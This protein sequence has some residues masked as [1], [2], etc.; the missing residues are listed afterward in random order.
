MPLEQIGQPVIFYAFYTDSGEGAVGLTV[1]ASVIEVLADGTA[2]EI[3]TDAAATEIGR[4]LYRYRLV[5]ASVDAQAEYIAVFETVDACDQAHIPAIWV[6]GKTWVENVDAAISDV[7]DAI[8][9]RGASNI[10]DVADDTSLG[11]L[12]LATFESK[13]D[14]TDWTIYKTD[15][16]TVFDTRTLTLSGTAQPIVE[17]T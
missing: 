3:V 4:G 12:V 13:I 6:V 11:A 7:P 17:V 8:L 2:A 9:I 14:G 16:A 15:H 10:E 5:G 1:T